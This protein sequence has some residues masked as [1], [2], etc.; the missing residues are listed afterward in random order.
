[1]RQ[2]GCEPRPSERIVRDGKLWTAAGV[3]AGIDLGLS[4]AAELTDEETARVQQLM[5]EYDP[6]PPF[7]SGHVSKASPATRARAEREMRQLSLTTRELKSMSSV[8]VRRWV[9]VLQRKV[10]GRRHA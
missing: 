1:L 8:L 4:L 9:D 10:R 2:F 3:S 6:Q 7:D 5:I